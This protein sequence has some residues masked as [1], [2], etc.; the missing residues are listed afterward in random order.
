VWSGVMLLISYMCGERVKGIFRQPSYS[1]IP[2]E[3]P[4]LVHLRGGL[5][6]TLNHCASAP[7]VG[8]SHL[9]SST[10]SQFTVC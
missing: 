6:R 9:L 5:P 1:A 10:V 3:E 4:F 2:D 8:F 7:S